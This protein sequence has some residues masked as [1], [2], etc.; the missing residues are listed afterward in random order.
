[1]KQFNLQFFAE[2]AGDVST[3][4]GP[5][6]GDT[7]GTD[8]GTEQVATAPSFDELIETNPEYKQ[9][10]EAHLKEHISKRF[11]NQKDNQAVIDRMKP[12]VAMQAQ[13]Y[14]IQAGEN[15]EYDF[16]AI[17][18]AMSNDNALYEEEA[19]KRGMNVEDYK[20]M[21]Q[22]EI[23]NE[24]LRRANQRSEQDARAREEFS[25]LV[26]EAERLKA[27]V[28]P[29]F[30]LSAELDNPLFG[31]LIANGF[32]VQNAYEAVHTQEILAG[33]MKYA[34]EKTK[35]N[36]SKTIQAGASRPRENGL[37]AQSA[38]NPGKIDISKLDSK[39]IADYVRRAKAGE[40]ITFR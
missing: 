9:A 32:N 38:S 14:G 23:E 10:Y 40:I 30:D 4:S 1:M 24:Q 16:N 27:T 8:T 3:E 28:Y 2:E 11:K 33:G 7:A 6:V 34:I 29:D 21:R 39:Q 22:M 17:A 26:E 25:K 37:S 13:K 15:G 19:F 5:I 35:E 12:L 36:V 31:K 20:H 18:E